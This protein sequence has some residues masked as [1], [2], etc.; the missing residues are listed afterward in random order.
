MPADDLRLRIT[1]VDRVSKTINKIVFAINK[2]NRASKGVNSNFSKMDQRLKVIGQT[3]TK[4]GKKMQAFGGGLT[5]KLTLPIG[6]FAGFATKKFADV[7]QGFINVRKTTGLA[8][9]DIEKSI[10]GISKRI[11]VSIQMLNEIAGA[12]G[13]L[14]VKG[15]QNIEKFTETFAKL[16]IASDVKGE[17]GAK[18]IARILTVTGDGVKTIDKFSSALVDLGNNSAAGEAEILGIATAISTSTSMF[19]LGSANVL[20]I[21]AA[22]KSLGQKDQAA[23]TVL[24][25]VFAA[26]DKSI[27]SGGRPLQQLIALTGKTQEELAKQFDTDSAGLFTELV[28]S[29]A[30]KGKRGLEA[31]ENMGV[32]GD[33]VTRVMGTLIKNH[34]LL[35]KSMKRS[36]KAY[37]DN[38]ALSIEVAEQS[39]SFNASMVAFRNAVTRLQFKLGRALA[40]AILWVTKRL[41]GM[42]KFLEDNPTIAK[43]AFALGGILAVMG[44]LIAA[45]GAFISTVGGILLMKGVLTALGISIGSVLLIAAKFVLIGVAIASVAN[46]IYKAWN[47]IKEFFKTL[48]NDPS[49][50]IQVFSA[51]IASAFSASLADDIM[52]NWG[53]VEDFFSSLWD[54]PIAAAEKFFG[55]LDGIKETA[56]GAFLTAQDALPS[57]FGTASDSAEQPIPRQNKVEVKN[58][59]DIG[60]K[61]LS[62]LQRSIG[63]KQIK[64][65]ADNREF[66]TRTNNARVSLDFKNKPENLSV[67]PQEDSSEFLDIN[68]G[69]LGAL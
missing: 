18:A 48:W 49:Q 10:F 33:R 63:A 16:Q 38:V 66:L 37:E 14:G 4:F 1:A 43:F 17:D 62:E 23:G 59:Q 6:V 36:N 34:G 56:R 61:N 3:A 46:L 35:E 68:N 13:Q 5:R 32:K 22:L 39:K 58:L 60:F 51:F 31:L 64:K 69:L 21:S 15:K 53:K 54:V 25:R 65:Q 30:S 45:V 44:P 40:P 42:M 20:G 9:K 27:R 29:L 52:E 7:E 8:L 57:V 50:A 12:A 19:K 28:A 11:P 2:I 41:A 47:P 67:R 26:I 24:G 55:V